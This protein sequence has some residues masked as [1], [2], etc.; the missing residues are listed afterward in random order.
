MAPIASSSGSSGGGGTEDEDD[1]ASHN[2]SGSS[3]F[4]T[5]AGVYHSCDDVVQR[6][7]DDLL[8]AAGVDGP[9]VLVTVWDVTDSNHR[10]TVARMC[11]CL[12]VLIV[13]VV[14][15]VLVRVCVHVDGAIAAT[16]YSVLC[17]CDAG[18]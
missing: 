5:F 15:A 8:L 3:P 13:G 1:A 11:F 4:A 12:T 9:P 17:G 7:V 16:S 2:Q 18:V 14:M 10:E 6:S